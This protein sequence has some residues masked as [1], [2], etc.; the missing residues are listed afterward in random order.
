MGR[1]C[2]SREKA[3][4]LLG[5]SWPRKAP[6]QVASTFTQ[7]PGEKPQNPKGMTPSSP[8]Q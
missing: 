7:S 2:H 1:Q 4:T 8:L 5:E 3:R 6:S